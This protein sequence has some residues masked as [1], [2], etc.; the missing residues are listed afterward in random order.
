MAFSHILNSHVKSSV[1][2][3][4]FCQE[5][6]N[7]IKTSKFF[8]TRITN[9]AGESINGILKRN[10]SFKPPCFFVET[11]HCGHTLKL[12]SA[13]YVLFLQRSLTDKSFLRTRIILS[14]IADNDVPVRRI[15]TSL[16]LSLL[17]YFVRGLNNFKICYAGRAIESGI[18]TAQSAGLLNVESW[19]I[20][21]TAKR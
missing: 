16:A 15:D 13:P 3:K 11:V 6:H 1:D 20:Y 18:L 12:C 2:I 9:E 4:E 5:L 10:N 14:Y 7:I 17:H 21:E 19:S 8:S